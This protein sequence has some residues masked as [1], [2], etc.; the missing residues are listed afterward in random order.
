MRYDDVLPYFL[1]EVLAAP[2]PMLLQNVAL[3]A[4]EFFRRTLMWQVDLDPI[5]ILPGEQV[6]DLDFDVGTE[7]A[8]LLTAYAD[9]DELDIVE[10]STGRRLVQARRYSTDFVYL[11]TLKTIGTGDLGSHKNLML[12]MALKPMITARSFP[13]EFNEHA[14]D[15]SLGA[16]ARTMMVPG[17][18]WSNPDYAS[19]KRAMFNDRI[20]TVGLQTAKG[21]SR[22]KVRSAG[23]FF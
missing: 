14:Q 7:L 17:Q 4:E 15:I 16:C 22:A 9:E 21:R 13:D 6:Y 10:R 23:F 8:K 19:A 2:Q 12:G 11:D 3:A 1:P 20:N 18:A 5:T